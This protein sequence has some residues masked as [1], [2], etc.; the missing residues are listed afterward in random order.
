MRIVVL[1]AG[2]MGSIIAGHLA[3]AGEDVTLIARGERARYLVQNG[4]TITG[5]SESNTHCVVASDPSIL[6]ES[7]VLIL[8]VKTHDTESAISSV[9]HVSVS[10]VLSVQNGVVADANI[11]R[12]FGKANTVG[13]SASFSEEVLPDGT[14]R[15]TVN[16]G[17][18][19][20]ELPDGTSERVL[21]LAAAL[22]RSGIHSTAVS[23]IQTMQ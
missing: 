5:L 9:D 13:A 3:R 22:E 17:F 19:V 1:G 6:S 11:S 15:F 14:V 2:A 23:N 10:S 8:A 20:G 12:V 18:Y 7:D 4:I 16:G 21:E